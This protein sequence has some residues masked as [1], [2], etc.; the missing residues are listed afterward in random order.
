[1]GERDV[2]TTRKLKSSGSKR[3]EHGEMYDL[4][5]VEEIGL[6]IVW[7]GKKR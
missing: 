3:A 1:V 7:S 5:A 2:K 6:T 4:T